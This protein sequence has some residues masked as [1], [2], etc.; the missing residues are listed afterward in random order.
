MNSSR[1]RRDFLIGLGAIAAGS[2][3]PQTSF[4]S[5]LAKSPFRVSV[6]NDEISQDFERACS[7]ASGFGMK[8][9]E[10]RGMW[11]KNV[12]DLDAHEISES[13][14]LLKKHDLRV[15]DIASPLFKVDWPGAP[16]SE[17]SPKQDQF[18]AHFGFDQQD[19]VLEKSIE[20]AKAFET[21]R[22]RCFDFWRL[23]D[24]KPHRAEMNEKLRQ[25]AEKAGKQGITLVL[26]NEAACN[27][28]T[29]KEAAEVLGA[30]QTPSLMLNWD[31]GN[32]ATLGDTPYPN[33]YD[34][35]P[36]ARIGHCHCK[37]VV[38][39][40]DKYEWAAVGKGFVD[41]VGQFKALKK[42]GYH[43]AVSL[44][45]HWRGA[46]SAEESTIQS[47]AGMKEALQKA[48]AL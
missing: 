23:D 14:R 18:N 26:E 13:K 3:F 8:W 39:N 41:W 21:D 46:G 10:L 15:T 20:L 35:L 16:K 36:K 22:V 40:G 24:I 25:A 42:D 12:L 44:E 45:T 37:D 2:V 6:I 32:A 31:P 34:L 19:E 28:G 27:T 9:I 5:D 33:G 29:G 38:K 30:V 43:H 48:Q 47:W 1:P 11:N 7:L 17:F 4:C